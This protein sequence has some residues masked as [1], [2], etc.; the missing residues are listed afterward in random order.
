MANLGVLSTVPQKGDTI[1]LDEL[2]HICIKEGVR[3]SRANYFNFKHNDLYD[4][5]KKLKKLKLE[6]FS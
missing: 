6:I 5:E 1:L 3:L 4:L 2:S